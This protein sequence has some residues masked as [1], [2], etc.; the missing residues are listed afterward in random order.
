MARVARDCDW[1]VPAAVHVL[2]HACAAV[3]AGRCG[4]PLPR[5]ATPG[6]HAARKRGRAAHTPSS[7]GGASASPATMA[8][9]GKR[10]RR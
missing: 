3:G 8:A 2:L 9:T 5:T 10:S 4:V 7:V 1:D 6:A